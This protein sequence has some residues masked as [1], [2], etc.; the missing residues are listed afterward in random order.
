MGQTLYLIA[1]S[2]TPRKLK[3]VVWRAFRVEAHEFAVKPQVVITVKPCNWRFWR[4]VSDSDIPRWFSS[5][6]L[7]LYEAYIKCRCLIDCNCRL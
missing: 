5:F 4:L 2:I 6:P 3:T 1:S 7:Y